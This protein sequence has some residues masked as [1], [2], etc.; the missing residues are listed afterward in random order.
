[1]QQTPLVLDSC[2]LLNLYASDQM[3]AISAALRC[4]FIIA[5]SVHAEALYVFR[6]G[7]GDD[8]SDTFPVDCTLLIAQGVL[9]VVTLDQD[10]E[11]IFVEFAQ[12]VDD[13][14]AA[15]LAL[16]L[17]RKCSPVTDDGKAIRLLHTRAPHVHHLSTLAVLKTWLD[18]VALSVPEA[19]VVLKMVC[20]RGHF[21]F[22]RRD[23]LKDWALSV[24]GGP[25][26]LPRRRSQ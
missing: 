11:A 23:P 16:A 26:T 7:D 19:R 3:V 17:H 12:E 2:S 10:E 4:T 5:E 13:G 25:V 8:A 18:Q 24:L 22:P 14:E 20:Q 6:G 9:S 15:T 1:M 21:D